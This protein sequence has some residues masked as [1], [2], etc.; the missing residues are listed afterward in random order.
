MEPGVTGSVIQA[1]TATLIWIIGG[2]LTIIAVLGAHLYRR[3]DRKFD[4]L[5]QKID[6]HEEENK[7]FRD[8]MLK[9]KASTERDIHYIR[10][11]VGL[12]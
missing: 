8:E 4:I 10:E 11:H 6:D 3:H 9:F 2:L 5:F 7:P 12:K 1:A